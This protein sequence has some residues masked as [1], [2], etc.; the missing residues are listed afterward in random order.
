M[1]R[2]DVIYVFSW[3]RLLQLWGGGAGLRLHDGL[4]SHAVPSA[5]VRAALPPHG[6]PV[7]G[8]RLPPVRHGRLLRRKRVRHPSA[9]NMAPSSNVLL[10]TY[11]V[12]DYSRGF[13]D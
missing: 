10:I 12:S 11:G 1:Q 9:S 8:V 5:R 2:G 4:P 13:W 3:R 7:H 6:A